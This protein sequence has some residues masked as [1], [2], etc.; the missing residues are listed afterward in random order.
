MLGAAALALIMTWIA[1]MILARLFGRRQP[2][3]A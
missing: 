2:A 3:H 1:F